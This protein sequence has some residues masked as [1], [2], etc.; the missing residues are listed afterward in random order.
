MKGLNKKIEKDSHC[1]LFFTHIVLIV[2]LFG[3]YVLVPID[4][5]FISEIEEQYAGQRCDIKTQ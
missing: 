3:K 5:P 1:C 2:F 4:I